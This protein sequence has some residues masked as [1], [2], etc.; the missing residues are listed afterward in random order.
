MKTIQDKRSGFFNI[1]IGKGERTR[2][3]YR[4]RGTQ[5]TFKRN[6]NYDV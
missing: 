5:K 6:L 3:I 2:V 4:L 1:Y